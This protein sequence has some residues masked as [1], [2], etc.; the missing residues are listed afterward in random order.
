M[1]CK[2]SLTFGID[3]GVWAVTSIELSHHCELHVIKSGR[4]KGFNVPMKG[5]RMN[6]GALIKEGVTILW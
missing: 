6:E 2:C 4:C 3:K 1:R 5:D